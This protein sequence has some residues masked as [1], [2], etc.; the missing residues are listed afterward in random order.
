MCL[1]SICH[2]TWLHLHSLH[3]WLTIS[4]HGFRACHAAPPR[5]LQDFSIHDY[6]LLCGSLLLG[7]QL[8]H[9]FNTVP[10]SMIF[11]LLSLTSL[12]L[13][14]ITQI[15]HAH[16]N[17][18]SSLLIS[19]PPMTNICYIHPARPS[20]WPQMTTK[21]GLTMVRSTTLHMTVD[22]AFYQTHSSR[23]PS[24]NLHSAFA[25][26]RSSMMGSKLS[27]GGLES[28]G[29]VHLPPSMQNISHLAAPSDFPHKTP[30]EIPPQGALP[31]P[32]HSMPLSNPTKVR[33]QGAHTHG[34]QTDV[35]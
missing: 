29:A 19:C 11:L 32:I 23:V 2:Y 30:R 15:L 9:I 35:Q 24:Y 34:S 4:F 20:T 13:I 22:L 33:G 12:L 6:E 25:H 17:S 8:G 28:N 14:P 7:C 5:P 18:H 16:F 31:V 1:E 27:L 3:S 26:A 10:A 21:S